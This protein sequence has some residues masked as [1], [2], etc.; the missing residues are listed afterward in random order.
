MCVCVKCEE[1]DICCMLY[2]RAVC[3][4]EESDICCMLCYRAVCM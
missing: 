3:M 1:S 4:C 2:Y